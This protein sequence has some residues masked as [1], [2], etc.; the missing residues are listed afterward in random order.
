MHLLTRFFLMIAMSI[1]TVHAGDIPGYIGEQSFRL[2]DDQDYIFVMRRAEDAKV[3]VARSEQAQGQL[4]DQ[5]RTLENQLKSIQD[6]MAQLMREADG[7]KQ[8]R[9]SLA[10]KLEELKKT[11]DVNAAA[12]TITQN[13]LISLDAQIQSKNQQAGQAKL[14]SSSVAVR[15]DQVRNDFNQALRRTEG[16][17]QNMDIV[18]RQRDDYRNS[19]LD[20][21]KKINYEGG[22][23]GQSDGGMDGAE[24]SARIG[25]DHGYADGLNDGLST[26][27]IDGQDRFY[28]RGADQGERDG[29]ARAR[30]DGLRDGTNE[31]TIAGNRS[32]GSREGDAAGIVRG[33]ASNAA[34]VGIGQGKKA[35]MERA[36]SS[37]QINGRNNGENETTKKLESGDLNSISINGSFAGSFQRT[38]PSYPGDFN[39]PNYKPNINHRQIVMIKAYADGYNFNYRQYSRFEFHRRID[40]D[41]NQRFDVSYKQAYDSAVNRDYPAYYDQGRRDADAKAYGRDYPVVKTDA[42]RIAFNQLDSNPNR[43]SGEFKT[44]YANSELEAYNDRYEEIRSANFDRVELAVFNANIAAQTE[45]YRQKRIAEVSNIYNGNAVLEFVSSEM[46]DAGISGVASLDGVFQPGETTGFNIVI[47][48]YGFKDATN[49]T[50]I[51][52]GGQVSK[53]PAIAA[54]SFVTVKGA[55]QG[56][57]T[58]GLNVVYRSALRVVSPLVS[59]DA[60]EGRH[61]D[62]LTGGIL[63]DADQKTVRAAYPLALS[64]LALNSQL[65]K[66]QKNNLK[67]TMTNNSKREYKGEL[68]IKLLANS[69]NG[70]ITK[71][72]AAVTS[73]QT[74]ASLNDAEI[75]VDADQDA[76]RDLSISAQVFQNGVLI[77]VLP[78]DFTTMAKAKFRDIGK[79]PVLVANTDKNLNAFLDALNTLGGSEKVSI[80]DLSLPTLNADAIAAGLNGKVLLMVDDSTGASIKSL[81]T[82]IGK[83]VSSTFVFID[84]SNS[85]LTNVKTLAVLKDAPNLLF[86]KRAVLFSNPHRAT[87]V[88]KSSVFMQSSAKYFSNDLG[89][90]QTLAMTAPELLAQIK[91]TV[92]P[93]NFNTPNDSIKVFSLKA[94]SEVM[95]INTAYDESGGIFSRDKK[96]AKMIEEDMTLFHNRMKTASSGDVVVSKLPV[97]MAAIAMRETLSSAMSRVDGISRDMKLKIQNTTNG[98]LKNME[99]SFSKSLKKDFKETYNKANAN[100]STHNPF[101]IPEA[102]TPGSGFN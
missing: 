80:L 78:Q 16:S 102:T 77:G 83:S 5:V 81:N 44:S 21:L 34:L 22:R 40:A 4:G 11:P 87:G 92:T 13:E 62:K 100:K 26:G 76:Y 17:R 96:W 51:L 7:L 56:A 67:I 74:S 27:T 20:Q 75:L 52:E 12:I 85:G 19:L 46:L 18:A 15:L 45:I 101:F 88:V 10:A 93:A 57:V 25:N 2:T 50:I 29:S 37:G 91:A 42:F 28:R 70:I 79:A 43:L 65:I 32:A 64:G 48:N 47:K 33:Y 89:L 63:K 53:L 84:D 35:G 68:K 9:I 54:R 39:G 8:M 24:L 98:V 49:V 3:E 6:R 99:D 58:A 94:L 38:T 30:I 36:V 41:Y 71:D 82:F 23:G 14:E 73:L 60:V 61:F 90:A 66:G 55:A 69:Q 97:V 86:G 59:N 95:C 1:G 72:F 31:G